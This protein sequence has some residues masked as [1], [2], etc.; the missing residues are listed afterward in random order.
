LDKE[1]KDFNQTIRDKEAE[2]HRTIANYEEHHS[3]L[4]RTNKR[5]EE[6]IA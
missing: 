4:T 3:N 5:L 2:F 6:R 1:G